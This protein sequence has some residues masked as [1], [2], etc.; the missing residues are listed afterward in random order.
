MDFIILKDLRI[1]VSNISHYFPTDRKISFGKK[2]CFEIE[3]HL[4]TQDILKI[5]GFETK[6]DR[7]VFLAK[8]DGVLLSHF[9]RS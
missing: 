2:M 5:D 7:N 1:S 4:K 3:I 6:N 9:K 8:M